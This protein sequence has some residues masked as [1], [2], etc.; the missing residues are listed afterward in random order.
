ML[1]SWAALTLSCFDTHW[2]PDFSKGEGDSWSQRL[3]PHGKRHYRVDCR[4]YDH[5]FQ[6]ID[7]YFE[8]VRQI[9]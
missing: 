2:Q 7:S 3:Q 5:Y 1:A 8:R 6:C 9:S 4:T